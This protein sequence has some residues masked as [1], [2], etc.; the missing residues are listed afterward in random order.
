MQRRHVVRLAPAQN[1]GKSR[2]KVDEGAGRL[3]TVWKLEWS[4]IRVPGGVQFDASVNRCRKGVD[5]THL[6]VGALSF[7]PPPVGQVQQLL[8]EERAVER[9]V[10][11]T[12]FAKMITVLTRYRPIVLE[13]I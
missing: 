12:I 1:S 8:R 13:L 3:L 2:E 10:C 5:I 4:R 11:S 6:N 7:R 9:Q